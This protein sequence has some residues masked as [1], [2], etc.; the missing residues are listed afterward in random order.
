MRMILT[1]ILLMTIAAC[2]G[3]WGGATAAL[4]PEALASRAPVGILPDV[5][6]PT[7]Y[8]VSLDLDPR[9]ARFSG[10]VEIDIDVKGQQSGLWMHGDDLNVSAVRVLAGGKLKT[11]KWTEVLPSGVAYVAFPST[12]NGGQLTLEIEYDAAFDANLSGLFKVEENGEA[13]ALAKSESIQARRFLPSFDQPGLKAPFSMQFRIPKGMHA[14]ANTPEISRSEAGDGFEQ[15]SFAPTRPLST[16]LLSVAV[17]NFDKVERAPIPPSALRPNPI[18][19]TGY[20]RAGKGAQ[21][22]YALSITPAYVLAFEEALQQPYPY[23]KLDIIAAPQWPSGATELA[24]AITYREG[25]IL[26]TVSTGSAQLLDLK[27][28]HAHEL[29][30]MWFGNLVTPPWW[31]DLWLKEGFATWSEGM[32]L[33]AVEP[34][35]GHDVGAVIEGLSAMS[36]DALSSARAI[37]QP[38]E[39]NE[40]IRNA[41]DAITY[42]KSLAVIGMVDHYFGPDK[43]RPALGKYIAAFVDDEADSADFFRVIGDVTDEPK[44]ED[45]FR[46]FVTQNGLPTIDTALSCKNGDVSIALKQTEFSALGAPRV[47]G[48]LWTIPVCVTLYAGGRDIKQCTLLDTPTG[49]MIMENTPCPEHFLPNSS[50]AGYYRF[51]V[52]TADWKKTIAHFSQLPPTEALVA[53]DSAQAAF[54]TTK[55]P[56]ADYL[57]IIDAGA[58]HPEPQVKSAVIVALTALLRRVEAT[59]AEDLAIVS[60]RRTVLKLRAGI[61]PGSEIQARLTAFEAAALKS[62]AKRNELFERLKAHMAGAKIGGEPPLSS[63][64]FQAAIK[65]SLERG[66]DGIFDEILAAEDRLDDAVFSGAAFNA[67]ATVSDPDQAERMRGLMASGKL[68]PANTFAIAQGQMETPATRDAMWTYLTENMPAFLKTIPT[69]WQRNTPRLAAPFCDT[70]RIVELQALFAAHGA[71]AEGHAQ[72]LAETVETLN[73]CAATRTATQ[74]DL[75]TAFANDL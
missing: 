69:Q 55:L 9:L 35:N 30:H 11:A 63:D 6:A 18:P 12:F 15:I 39:R 61:E 43:F 8:R 56:A 17:G 31:N 5:A 67:L 65:V 60:A 57:A 52:S 3:A 24:A 36:L 21:L 49:E 27:Q 68:A 20:A 4:T 59:P 29:A 44:I 70:T 45:V 71:L 26:R 41:Y 48:K 2:G 22:D 53:L 16:Y 40:D 25:R 32:L 51:E 75:E 47:V 23:E 58:A 66:G 64:L 34:G 1:L 74:R 38:V 50:G 10:T 33:S 42:R 73:V 72:A 37:S 14:I 7:A 62:S 54:E 13:Y 19:L 46:G 28:I